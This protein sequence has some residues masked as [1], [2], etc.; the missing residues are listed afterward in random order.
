MVHDAGLLGGG[1]RATRAAAIPA[2]TA[3]CTTT[4]ASGASCPV[5]VTFTPPGRG[6]LRRDAGR[7]LRRRRPA[8]RRRR[9]ARLIGAETNL[10]LLTVHDWSETDNGGGDLLRL[11]HRRRRG[12][13]H[14]HDHQRRRAGRDAD[15]DGGGLGNGFAWK[16]GTYPG[17]TG[18]CGTSLAPGAPLHGGR[19]LLAVGQP[20]ARSSLLVSYF[21][22]A[23]SQLREARAAGDRHDRGAAA[24]Q[25]LATWRR[26]VRT[27]PTI[28]RP[29]TTAPAGRRST[30]VFTVTNWGGSTATMVADG[31][32][33]GGGFGW[34]GGA[35]V[36][37]RHLRRPARAGRELHRQRDVHAVGRRTAHEHADDRVRR[38]RRRPRI[39]T[40]GAHRHG[41]DEGDRERLRLR[42]ARRRR[43]PSLDNRPPFD[44]RRLGRRRRLTSSR[45]A[46]TAAALRRWSPAAARW[47]PA[48]AGRTGTF[49]GTNGDCG[50][51]LAAGATCTVV[52]TFTPSG[53]ATLFGQVRVSYSDGGT[54]A[55]ATRAVT[56]TPTARA[57][58]TVA[59]FFGP[60]NCTNCGPFG[61][62]TVAV[63]S[64]IE[65]T[66]TV[67]NTGALTATGARAGG[68]SGV[69]VRVQR[70]VGISGERRQLRPDARAEQPVSAGRR[71]RAPEAVDRIRH[72][73]R[74]LRR[75]LHLAPD[76]VA[77]PRRDR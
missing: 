16:G 57:H 17:A 20:D 22:G 77:R 2:R 66:F 75:H 47:G 7:R 64:T 48:S 14:L 30:H 44:Y 70:D 11:R 32:T 18:T 58:V 26:R 9:P 54:P 61:F 15:A 76:C 39:A 50:A 67:Y 45:C 27:G 36:R 31:G 6:Q 29:T 59:E 55:T 21:D 34:T 38:R 1:L 28:R 74:R 43:G 46:T 40:R 68:R 19:H 53:T 62:G 25:R 41:D 60:N 24:G 5:A 49:P 37:R 8:R 12:R 3:I 35:R 69:A 65:Q 13:P 72:A 33:L 52:V 23:N 10:A 42:R 71:V 51:T 73:G 63:G 4:L 56:G